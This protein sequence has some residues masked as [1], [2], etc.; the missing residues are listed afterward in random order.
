MTARVRCLAVL[1]CACTPR[2]VPVHREPAPVPPPEEV[3]AKI[4]PTTPTPIDASS[5]D[6]HADVECGLPEDPEQFAVC[7]ANECMRWDAA[8]M[9]AW[10]TKHAPLLAELRPAVGLAGIPWL[11]AVG[12]PPGP[13]ERKLR[14]FVDA[15]QLIWTAARCVAIDLEPHEGNLV[16]DI[17]E[18]LGTKPGTKNA[19]FYTLQLS[20]GVAVL[21]PGRIT[22][23]RDGEGAE[24]IGGLQVFGHSLVPDERALRYTGARFAAE[25]A[26]GGPTVER[27]R[28]EPKICTSCTELALRK[29]SLESGVGFGGDTR[30]RVTIDGGSCDPCP[31]DVFTPSLPR[32]QAALVGR[33]FVD[34][35]GDDSGPIFYRKQKDCVAALKKKRRAR[36]G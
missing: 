20:G 29:R 6:C 1:A 35:L 22:S 8:T 26:C 31:V 30:V 7:E 4:E 15:R 34:D 32:L 12:D 3:R 18:R 13:R 25:L 36:S 33:S 27:T 28:C 16:A 5:D 10:A 21:G 14:V 24:A 11:A 23:T 17:P 2:Y 9:W 19:W